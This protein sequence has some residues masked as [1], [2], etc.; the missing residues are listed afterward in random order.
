MNTHDGERY[1]GLDVSKGRLDVA[2]RPRGR[3]S[4]GANDPGGSRI[5]FPGWPGSVSRWWS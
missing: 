2:L 5:S 4:S 1:A 3:R